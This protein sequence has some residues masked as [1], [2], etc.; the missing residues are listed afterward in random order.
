MTSLFFPPTRRIHL[1]VLEGERGGSFVLP[2]KPVCLC[3]DNMDGADAEVI[4][5]K[6]GKGGEG[7][8]QVQFVKERT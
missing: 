3:W 6:S 8:G 2:H 5:F 4:C 1:R 7:G